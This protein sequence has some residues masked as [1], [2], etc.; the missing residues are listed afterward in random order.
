[1]SLRA[2]F[3]LLFPAGLVIWAAVVIELIIRLGAG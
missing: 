3:W 2:W 1:M